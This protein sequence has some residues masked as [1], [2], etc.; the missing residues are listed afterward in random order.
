MTVSVVAVHFLRQPQEFKTPATHRLAFFSIPPKTHRNADGSEHRSFP[1]KKSSALIET[2]RP[3][4]RWEPRSEWCHFCNDCITVASDSSSNGF[5]APAFQCYHP[6][7]I[8]KSLHLVLTPVFHFL[9]SHRFSC[10]TW[11]WPDSWPS[12]SFCELERRFISRAYDSERW[13]RGGGL[14]WA[15]FSLVGRWL[16]CS[17]FR[18]WNWLASILHRFRDVGSILVWVNFVPLPLGFFRLD[19]YHTDV[20]FDSALRL[21]FF[22]IASWLI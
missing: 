8:A 12:S 5:F 17:D 1:R 22:G 13:G 20:T 14:G 3:R 18:R 19:P 4:T 2:D 10:W 21:L 15:V 7:P 16:I 9:L 6:L 11:P